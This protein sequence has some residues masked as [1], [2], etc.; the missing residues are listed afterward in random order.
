MPRGQFV[1]NLKT[2]KMI[3]KGY[4]YHIVRVRDVDSETPSFESVPMVNDS[5][6][7]SPMICSVFFPN[8]K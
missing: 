4:F 7:F 5:Q 6:K 8:G 3:L 2:R 1:S